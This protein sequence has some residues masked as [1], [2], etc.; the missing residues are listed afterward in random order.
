M[1]E[2]KT[3]SVILDKDFYEELKEVAKEEERNFSFI[4]RKAL[5]EYLDK[6]K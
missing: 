3:I 5:Q 1:K 4:V 6:K 2:T